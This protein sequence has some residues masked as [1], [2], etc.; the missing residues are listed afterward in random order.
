MGNWVEV[1]PVSTYVLPPSASSGV[2]ETGR[3]AKAWFCQVILMLTSLGVWNI[4][5]DVLTV[6]V[7]DGTIIGGWA[8]V[9]KPILGET[10]RS[11]G[12][13]S[14]VLSLELGRNGVWGIYNQG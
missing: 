4:V 9:G 10:I 11:D 12:V 1:S 3:P 2:Q 7:V 13:R 5:L 8:G 14:G 6:A